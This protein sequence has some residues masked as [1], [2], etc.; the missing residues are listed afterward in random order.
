[1][2]TVF[3][4]NGQISTGKIPRMNGYQEFTNE[5]EKLVPIMHSGQIALD[6][7]IGIMGEIYFVNNV[8]LNILT[9]RNGNKILYSLNNNVY[10]RE[11]AVNALISF[12]RKAEN[13]FKSSEKDISAAELYEHL[14][15]SC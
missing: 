15:N 8:N 5:L 14:S 9:Q 11:G 10:E 6:P 1:M 12:R 2:I 3:I 4:K 13:V 7:N